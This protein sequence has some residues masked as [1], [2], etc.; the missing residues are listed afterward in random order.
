MY[1][2]SGIGIHLEITANCNS[3]CLDCGRYIKGTDIINPDVDVGSK[4]N[5]SLGVVNNVFDP[6][7]SANAK[8]VNFT[9]TYGD[10]IIHPEF[11][12]ILKTIANNVNQQ[13]QSRLDA[14]LNPKLKL[15]IET[16]GG[17]HSTEWWTEFAGIV[18]EHFSKDSIIIFAIDGTDNDTHQL[19][20]RGIDYNKVIA[21]ATAA[22]SVG[23][24][25]VWSMISFA[26]NEHQLKQAKELSQTLGFKQFKIRRSRL[27]SSTTPIVAPLSNDFQKN[28]NI[29]N[30]GVEY[31][32]YMT[33]FFKKEDSN[34]VH[35]KF[36]FDGKV[37]D[38]YFDETDIVC[39]WLD[40]KKINVDYTSRVWQCCYFST[41]YHAPINFNQLDQAK[42]VDV[43][44][45]TREFENLDHYEKQY[46]DEWNF[47][48]T[49]T[50][51]EILNHKFFTNDLIESFEKKMDDTEFPRIYRCAKHCGSKA[52]NLDNQLR[53]ANDLIVGGGS[54]S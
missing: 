24:N 42:D 20:R 25:A 23:I 9:G 38:P 34:V 28:K 18:K 7:I 13:Q 49:H 14:G 22:I 15:M 50:L 1:D 48:T 27:R 35:D 6:N 45:R 51:S 53:Q 10:A 52:R 19:Y 33:Q 26:H 30:V 5:M 39:E 8:Y 46:E 32:T 12:T 11:F 21:N 4:G 29:S 44:L 37:L 17:L 2:L 16:N 41:F 40:T 43:S 31:S 54:K 47:C 36:Y 3:R